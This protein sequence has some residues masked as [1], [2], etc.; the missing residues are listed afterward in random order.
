MSFLNDLK[1]NNEKGSANPTVKNVFKLIKAPKDSIATN[2]IIKNNLMP[3]FFV[4]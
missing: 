4:G 1:Y 3:S 2:A